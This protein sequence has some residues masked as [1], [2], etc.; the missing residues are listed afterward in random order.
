M[1][2]RLAL[3]IAQDGMMAAAQQQQQGSQA[4][5]VSAVGCNSADVGLMSRISRMSTSSNGS[6][7][8]SHTLATSSMRSSATLGTTSWQSNSSSGSGRRQRQ[9]GTYST[10]A[11]LG[12]AGEQHSLKLC[13]AA[14]LTGRARLH[15][16]ASSFVLQD[17]DHYCVH[18]L[19]LAC[20]LRCGTP[21]WY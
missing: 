3:M 7:R 5:Q 16:A 11:A 19:Q 21:T 1:A 9:Q 17:G 20:S 13:A 10:K 12:P 15:D 6:S 2:A 4:D 14:L 18:A 8:W